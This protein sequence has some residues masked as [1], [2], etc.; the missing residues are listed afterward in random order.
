MSA[1]PTTGGA[2]GRVVRA[3]VGRRRTQTAVM[4]LTTLL[5]VASA[6]LALGLLV[7][8]GAPFDRAFARQHGAH[9]TVRFDG[10]AVTPERLAATARASGVAAASGP[11]AVTSLRLSADRAAPPGFAPPPLTVVGRASAAG[12]VDA[13]T[14]V[15]GRW[16]TAPGEIVLERGSEPPRT[17]PGVRVTAGGV[18]LT[19]VG[20]AESVGE[21]ADAWVVP[22]QLTALAGG[23]PP[24]LQMLYRL[25][26]ADTAAEVTAGRKAV[27]AAVPAGAVTGARSYLDV[28]ETARA[29]T[30]AFVPFVTAFAFLGLALSVLV[31][32]IVVSGAVGAATRRIGILKSLGFTPFQVGRA[33]VAQALIPGTVGAVL[34]VAL[35][36]VLAVPLMA[37]VSEVYGTTE[38]LIPVWVD[39][40][41]PAGGLALVAA[42]AF[43]PALR[44][45]RLPTATVL[46]MGP[47]TGGG[48]GRAL[49]GLLGRLPLP[50]PVTLG[51]AAPFARPARAASTAAAVTFGALAVTFAVG[52]GST[53]VAIK[54]DGDPDRG[55]D[56]TVHTIAP[57]HGDPGAPGGEMPRQADPAAVAAAIAALPGTASVYRTARTQLDVA[58]LKGGAPLVA[59]EGDTAGSR[60]TMVS[61]RWFGATGEAVAP[62]R[63]LHT[64]GVRV[65]DTVTLSEQ[66]RTARV[67]IVGE[68]FDLGDDGMTLRTGEAS[69]AALHARYQPADFAVTVTG[70]TDAARYAERL[71]AAVAPLGAEA[72]L[73]EGSRSGVIRAMQALIVTLTLMLVV[74]ACLGVLDMVVLDTRD[75]VRD[76]G[77]FKALGMTPRQTVAQ[78]LTSVGAIG[79]LSGAVGVPLGVALHGWVMPA[80]GRAV[81]TTIPP[82]DIEVYGTPLLVLL[83]AAGVV[84]ATAGALL[85]AGWAARTATARALRTE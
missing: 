46:R 61:G 41:V 13:V 23:R 82:A 42:T 9:L 73:T 19:V 81:G 40:A 49:L 45:A 7:A 21:S 50:R 44:A 15:E 57:P 66:G 70:G 38:I 1:D 64:T 3:G 59:Y 47:A 74:V 60:H 5:S 80:M 75:R 85:P 68:V 11:F 12:P 35:G 14:V 63:F 8:S 48:R 53:L 16:A 69:V 72:A 28:R 37:E 77:V 20:I 22:E 6:V 65:G 2:L 56:V 10:S 84:I 52:L 39:L 29:A 76:L 78:V 43:G 83:A 55:G 4:V 34:G 17:G 30:A 36:N 25:T 18:T 71:D 51:L 31:I 54:A 26:A 67:R 33:Y 79:L 58:G 24:A 62:T 27:T 32:G